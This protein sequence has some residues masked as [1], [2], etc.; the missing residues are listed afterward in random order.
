VALLDAATGKSKMFSSVEIGYPRAARISPNGKLLATAGHDCTVRVFDTET[1][2]NVFSDFLQTTLFAVG[3]S[4]DGHT[5]VAGSSWGGVLVIYSV[6]SDGGKAMIKKKGTSR[7]GAGELYS[8]DFSPDGKR[9]LSNS[10]GGIVLWDATTW[11]NFKAL[12]DAYGCL[13]PD[14]NH[15]AIA[16]NSSPSEVQIWTLHDL[17]KTMAS[18]SP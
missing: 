3:F 4:P 11:K 18:P 9:A 7:P 15:A 14:G 10:S 1:S 6:N 16:R 5:L 8:I 12:A 17:E 13:S 2:T